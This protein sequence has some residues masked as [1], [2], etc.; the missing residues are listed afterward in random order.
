MLFCQQLPL[1]H[2][3]GTLDAPAAGTLHFMGKSVLDMNDAEV[4]EFRNKSIGFVFQ[5]HYLLPDLPHLAAR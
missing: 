3:V 4:A 5:S 2:V 1:W